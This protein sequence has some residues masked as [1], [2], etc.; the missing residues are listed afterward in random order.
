MRT[1]TVKLTLVVLGISLLSVAL[2][3]L[4]ARWVT[5]REFDRFVL[6]QLRG[7]FTEQVTTYYQTH[8]SWTG[9]MAAL[10]PLPNPGP[11]DAPPGP[12]GGQRA[13]FALLDAQGCVVVP[14]DRFRLGDC[15]RLDGPEDRN[16]L[17]IDD[18][19][20]GTVITIPIRPGRNE[21]EAAYMMRT[22]R[23]LVWGALSAIGL[24]LLLSVFFARTLTRPLQTLTKAIRAMTAGELEQAV[25]V[26]SQDELGELTVAFNQMSADLAH[27]NGARR[28]MTADIAHE[29]RN[30]LMVMM[31]YI[32]AMRDGVLQPTNERLAMMYDEA[33]HLQRLVADLRT[34]SL[35]DTGELTLQKEAIAPHDLLRRVANAYQ[36]QASQKQI[37]LEVTA[38]TT[39]PEIMLDE[40]RMVQVLG[41]LVANALRHTPVGGQIILSAGI[42]GATLQLAVQDNGEGIPPAALPHVFDR[43]YRA[44]PARQQTGGESGLGL[45]IARSIVSAHGGTI[46]VGSTLGAG[47]TFTITLAL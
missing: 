4:F 32:E 11:A 45:A 9:V 15:P 12:P 34:L 14:A 44:D 47:A 19:T 46:M 30:P 31:G 42:D 35:A 33:L 22:N 39:L 13:L 41:N 40:E 36:T 28:T 8:G 18:K 26:Q 6:G 29:L 38:P 43:F 1:L 23:A 5:V 27:A 21:F 25:P 10:P 7:G 37:N 16:A 3:A 24:A 2:V 17:T 20:V